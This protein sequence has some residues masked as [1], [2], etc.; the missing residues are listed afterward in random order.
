LE[1]I[2]IG[3]L[4]GTFLAFMV[5]HA[6]DRLR[7]WLGVRWAAIASVA[8]ASVGLAATLG[9]LGWLFVAKGTTLAR[10]LIDA[11]KP[12][13]PGDRALTALGH[14]T[15]RVGISQEDLQDKARGL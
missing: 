6:H 11:F 5:E 12:G 4:L 1:P 10:M 7:G 13:A 15:A 2:G 3:I 8:G 14:L 9:G